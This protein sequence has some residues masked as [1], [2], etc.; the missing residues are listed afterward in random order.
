MAYDDGMYS[1]VIRT[2]FWYVYEKPNDAVS[3]PYKSNHETISSPQ[4]YL[5]I[6]MIHGFSSEKPRKLVNKIVLSHH[7]RPR[8]HRVLLT[9]EG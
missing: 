7:L 2:N 6:G 9:H 8:V 5:S 4:K 1:S 3:A